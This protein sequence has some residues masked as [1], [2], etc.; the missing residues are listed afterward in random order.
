MKLRRDFV[1]VRRDSIDILDGS[2]AGFKIVAQNELM[3]VLNGF[4]VE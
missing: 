1:N 4:A 3:N 2:F